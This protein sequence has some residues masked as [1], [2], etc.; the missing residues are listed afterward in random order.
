MRTDML[1]TKADADTI[2]A[3]KRARAVT[4]VTA[5][6]LVLLFAADRAHACRFE[7]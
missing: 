5:S 1:M 3:S 6:M 2:G 4:A 7:L